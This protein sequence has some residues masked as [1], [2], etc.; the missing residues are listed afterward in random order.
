MQGRWKVGEG[1]RGVFLPYLLAI[2]FM[3]LWEWSCT[4]VAPVGSNLQLLLPL[5]EPASSTSPQRSESQLQGTLSL[6]V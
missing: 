1:E 5:P 3:L 4:P 2:L 6:N